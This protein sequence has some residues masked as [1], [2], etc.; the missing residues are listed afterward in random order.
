MT[1]NLAFGSE[2][3]EHPFLQAV[4]CTLPQTWGC[5]G[6]SLLHPRHTPL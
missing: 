5:S 3:K 6:T 1:P 2:P 4:F